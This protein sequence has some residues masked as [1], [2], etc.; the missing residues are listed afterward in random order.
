MNLLDSVVPRG[1]VGPC[2]QTIRAGKSGTYATAAMRTQPESSTH[3]AWKNAV[4]GNEPLL[5]ALPYK[6]PTCS[7]FRRRGTTLPAP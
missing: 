7:G 5:L 2:P 4:Q 3:S 6:R 1:P